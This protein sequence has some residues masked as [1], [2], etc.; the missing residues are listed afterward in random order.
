MKSGGITPHCLN[1]GN[2]WSVQLHVPAAWPQTSLLRSLGRK[3]WGTGGSPQAVKEAEV[4]V[5]PGSR[6]LLASPPK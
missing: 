5:P 1:L 2:T 3:L 4:F 6:I